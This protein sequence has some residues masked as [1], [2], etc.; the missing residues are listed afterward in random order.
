MATSEKLLSTKGQDKMDKI[1]ANSEDGSVKEV[2]GPESDWTTAQYANF[3]FDATNGVKPDTSIPKAV[4]AEKGEAL[5]E[6]EDDDAKVT[7][8]EAEEDVKD[9]DEELDE[10]D[11]EDGDEKE[12]KADDETDVEV[13]VKKDKKKDDGEGDDESADEFSLDLSDLTDS[14]DEFVELVKGDGDGPVDDMA[15]VDVDPNDEFGFEPDMNEMD[16][17]A[18]DEMLP[19]PEADD[20][21]VAD[22][23]EEF[24][25]DDEL[26][27]DAEVKDEAVD[28]EFQFDDE[29]VVEAACEIDADDEKKLDEED[30]AA[31]EEDDKAKAKKEVKEGKIR[32]N[33]KVPQTGK[34][35]EGNTVLTEEDKR[36]S[37]VLFEAAVRQVAV[38]VAGK[39]QETY[40]ARYVR[41]AKLQER[42]LAK[43]MDQ[44]LTFVVEN[45]VKANKVAMRGQINNRLS[46]SLLKGIKNLFL[47]HYVDIPASRV[48]VVAALTKN[49]KSLQS[50]VRLAEAT[51][52]KQDKEMRTAVAR[53]R[54]SL[55]KEHKARLI[56]EAA[57]SMVAA[58][59]GTFSKRAATVR[60]T[61]TKSFKK[62]LVALREQYLVARKSAGRPIDLPVATPLFEEKKKSAFKTTQTNVD[63]YTAALDKLSGSGQS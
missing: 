55:I 13:V 6:E 41:K 45:W 42:R 51:A 16:P 8:D 50:K 31:A 23:D 24:V 18:D 20:V 25:F 63:L 46:E 34:L 12:A 35:F 7:D 4:K 38:K 14:N 22:E 52:V 61:N 59:R 58:E 37:R 30:D 49:V 32:L 60:F 43:Q 48:N 33:F 19:L 1:D 62:D 17:M 3:S 40:Q 11:K 39:L 2:G 56:A 15:E 29:P 53:E 26:E 36:Q 47:E 9:D 27:G 5:K 57:G 10:A 28:P 21:P 44:Y 54:L